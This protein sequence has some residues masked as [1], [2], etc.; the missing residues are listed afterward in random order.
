MKFKFM[1]ATVTGVL[2]GICS[3]AGAE[4][5][6]RDNSFLLEE[7]YNQEP[8]VIQHITTF[9]H[10]LEDDA[11]SMRFT[12]EWPFFGMSHQL[13][14]TVALGAE[15]D[16][17]L[18]DVML[19]YRHQILAADG[20]I[21]LAPRLSVLLPAGSGEPGAQVNLPVSLELRPIVIHLN[22]G[23]TARPE[24]EEPTSVFAGGSLIWLATSKINLLCEVW[25]TTEDEDA[26]LV[27]PG[28]R[29]AIDVGGLQIVPGLA[30]PIGVG[31]SE[32]TRAIF[33]YLSFEHAAF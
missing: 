7:A 19:N 20:R 13:S 32:G 31:P 25:G 14:V 30:V 33:A 3:T 8:G 21:A 12:E 5:P 1:A 18:E 2:A 16:A 27:S 15:P 24:T 22:A 17:E 4:E 26:L 28:V 23:A 9:T 11:W 6:I 29:G 10:D